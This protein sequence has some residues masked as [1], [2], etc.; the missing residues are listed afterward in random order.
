M[1][2]YPKEVSKAQ[3]SVFCAPGF[4]LNCFL[5]LSGPSGWIYLISCL[6][7][8][9]PSLSLLFSHLLF[10]AHTRTHTLSEVSSGQVGWKEL[11]NMLESNLWIWESR[12]ISAAA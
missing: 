5:L 6:Q 7:R 8:P 3:K 1:L 12:L 11:R 2:N 4:T 10:H 9:P